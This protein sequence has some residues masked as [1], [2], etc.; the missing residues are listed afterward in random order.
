MVRKKEAK[1]ITRVKT[2]KTLKR[3]GF[4]YYRRGRTIGQ[5][6]SK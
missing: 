5:Y 6:L 2:K 1:L 3:K 4:I